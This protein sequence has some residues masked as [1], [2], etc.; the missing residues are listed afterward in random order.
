MKKDPAT[1]AAP[2]W[3]RW[4]C[5]AAMWSAEQAE[6]A[7]VPGY[8]L[9][10]FVVPADPAK[11]W[12]REIGWEVHGGAKLV[13]LVA[14]GGADSIDDAKAQAVAAWQAVRAAASR[15]EP[16]AKKAP[17]PATPAR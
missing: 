13:D 11:G 9:T 2:H 16:N 10:A 12:E 4:K 3:M 6:H 7:R 14:K 17:R 8:E 1:D 5:L 15:P